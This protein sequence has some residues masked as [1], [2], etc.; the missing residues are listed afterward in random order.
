MAVIGLGRAGGS[1]ARAAARAELEVEP[2]G[3]DGALDAGRRAEAALLCVPDAASADVGST[4]E[5]LAF[6][7][8]L[9]AALGMPPFALADE[10]RAA[11]YALAE[12]ARAIA[13][14]RPR[15]EALAR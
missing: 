5:A 14:D 10:D 7:E 3:H 9:A 4:A 6:A 2:A 8:S 1:I 15:P 13:A 11:Y 12:R